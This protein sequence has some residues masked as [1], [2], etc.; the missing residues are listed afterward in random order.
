MQG[1]DGE[2]DKCPGS[3]HAAGIKK[4]NLLESAF[5]GCGAPDR[6]RTCDLWLRKPTLYPTELRALNMLKQ[7]RIIANA[8]QLVLVVCSALSV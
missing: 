6:S 7:R 4:P 2:A 5:F 3:L 1:G 8:M